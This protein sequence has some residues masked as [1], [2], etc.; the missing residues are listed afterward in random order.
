MV[1]RRPP[2]YWW[3]LAM[4]LALCFTVLSWSLCY[5]IFSNPE[6]PRNYEILKRLGRTPAHTN[7]TES[8]QP[9]LNTIQPAA[10]RNKFLELD[11]TEINI[12]NQSLKHSFLTNFK[13]HTFCNY[14]KGTYKVVSKR[15]LTKDD[16]ISDGFAIQLRAYTQADEYTN[17]TPYPVIVEIIFPTIHRKSMKGYHIGD[18]L[19]IDKTPYFASVLHT[20]SI[21]RDNDDTII[22]LTAISLGSK[23]RPPHEGA[24]DLKAP[25]EV[26]LEAKF[27]LFESVE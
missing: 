20:S 25:N 1:N 4:I 14:I 5:A 17:A 27:P 24:F 18:I 16:F 13:K 12:I 11:E 26:N 3:F 15:E 6:V 22:V 7:Y 9:K 21:I 10:L 8:A 23:L 2:Y 19:T